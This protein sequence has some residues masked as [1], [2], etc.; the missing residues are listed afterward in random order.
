MKRNVLTIR[1][2]II[3]GVQ[4]WSEVKFSYALKLILMLL[5]Q[6]STNNVSQHV[7]KLFFRVRILT[8]QTL[9]M[10]GTYVHL[11]QQYVSQK[12]MIVCLIKTLM[13]T[14][15]HVKHPGSFN[16]AHIFLGVKIC[17]AVTST[18]VTNNTGAFPTGWSAMESLIVP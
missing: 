16:P 17:S 1:S 12:N 9:I 4:N 7:Q 18:F 11:A 3:S 8:V 13:E 5:M 6:W 14:S 15:Y 2:M 10:L